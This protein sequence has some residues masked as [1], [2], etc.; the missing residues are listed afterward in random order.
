VWLKIGRFQPT[1]P[2][3]VSPTDPYEGLA[4]ILIWKNAVS[5][6]YP[7]APLRELWNNGNNVTIPAA[8]GGLAILRRT[9]GH[10]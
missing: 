5:Q 2:F 10:S 4:I 6:D 8:S 9:D 3:G 1:A 7:A